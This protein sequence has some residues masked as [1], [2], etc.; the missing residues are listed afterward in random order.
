M[1]VKEIVSTLSSKG[2]VTIPVEVRRQ[3][4]IGTNERVVFV[5]DASG[6]VRLTAPR[7]PTVAALAGAA[8][9]LHTSRSWPEMRRIAHEDRLAPKAPKRR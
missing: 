5:I 6:Q 2:Q 3:L 7:F 1:P 8:G 9:S 4:G